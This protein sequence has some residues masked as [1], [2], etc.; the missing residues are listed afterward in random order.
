MLNREELRE[1]S[2]EIGQGSPEQGKVNKL[3]VDNFVAFL[4]VFSPAERQAIFKAIMAMPD[5]PGKEKSPTPPMA[6][7]LGSGSLATVD[8]CK[9]IEFC[10]QEFQKRHRKLSKQPYIDFKATEALAHEAIRY[11][12]VQALQEY[13]EHLEHIFQS[14]TWWGFDRPERM[15]H[16]WQSYVQKVKSQP[17]SQPL[18]GSGEVFFFQKLSAHNIDRP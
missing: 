17:A 8:F 13:V 9:R 5:F 1:G 6:G 11:G 10:Y 14:E 7:W 15:R 12:G 18:S 3:L 16:H 2:P 4:A